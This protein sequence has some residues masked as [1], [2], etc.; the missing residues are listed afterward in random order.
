MG[1]AAAEEEAVE[2]PKLGGAA[3][4]EAA[5]DAPAPG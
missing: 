3:A 2:K 5:A 1:A 4:V